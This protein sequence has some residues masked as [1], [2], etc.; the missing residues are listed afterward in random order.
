MF[1]VNGLYGHIQHNLFK[2][3]LLLISFML[4]VTFFHIR[5]LPFFKLMFK[6]DVQ[7]EEVE[8]PAEHSKP[9]PA[10]APAR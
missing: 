6:R 2:S 10:P 5:R 4:Y 9:A 8:S 1:R 3:A 7:I